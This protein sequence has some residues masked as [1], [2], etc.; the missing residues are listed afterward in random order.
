[1]NTSLSF[2]NEI[3]KK[4]IINS[5]NK[6]KSYL[7]R[8]VKEQQNPKTSK[9]YSFE[10]SMAFGCVQDNFINMMEYSK[11]DIFTYQS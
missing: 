10:V 1:M 2:P 4:K 3:V 5:L 6:L 9:P 11:E 7:T 8:M